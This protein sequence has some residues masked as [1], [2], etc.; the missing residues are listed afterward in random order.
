[1]ETNGQRNSTV[2]PTLALAGAAVFFWLG[3]ATGAAEDRDS[4]FES[5]WREA[6]LSV[7]DLDRSTRL[8]R[9]T[10]QFETVA[11]GSLTDSELAYWE[12][13]N[14]SDAEYLL[15]RAPGSD[16]GYLRFIRFDNVE[17][18]PIRVGARAWDTGGYFSLMMRARGLEAI[19][20]DALE[21]G[22]HAESEPVQFEF[23][24]FELANVVLKGP[25]GIN[26]ALYERLSPPLDEFWDFER[27][28]QP[29]NAM[30]MVADIER[31]IPSLPISW[32]WNTSG[33]ATTSIRNRGQIILVCR[34]I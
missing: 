2:F 8:F 3:A 31:P 28:S 29:F 33:R 10:G 11:R 34:R 26:I 23:P 4:V 6:T 24:P 25:H 21:L 15:L 22:W 19:Y 17:Q 14:D 7:R 12:L 30:Q 32:A 9:Q 16:H 13:G 5:P 18:Q 20:A 27:L 1:M